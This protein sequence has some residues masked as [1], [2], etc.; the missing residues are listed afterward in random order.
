M[1][2]T[3]PSRLLPALFEHVD[4]DWPLTVL[5]IGP[6]LPETVN[7]FSDY[8]CKLHF[9]DLYEELPLRRGA[10]GEPS[11]EQRFERA[12]ALPGGALFDL[13]F[14]WD[15]LNFLN[16]DA[17]GALMAMLRPHL[18]PDSLGHCFAPHNAR[19]AASSQYYGIAD[20]GNLTVRQ[21]V[22]IP[23]DYQPH[24]Q[25]ELGSLLPCF[26]VERSVLLPDRRTELLLKARLGV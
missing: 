24:P 18:H 16:R 4:D 21:R 25:G 13:C 2:T 15:V 1:T 3:Q 7:F 17:I 11:L 9:A 14:F 23:P 12:L 19:T 6:A 8:R 20:S 26:R 22:S 5:H 10:E